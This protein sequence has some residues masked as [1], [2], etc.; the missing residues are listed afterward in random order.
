M[1]PHQVVS[2]ITGFS[3]MTISYDGAIYFAPDITRTVHE[4]VF[5]CKHSS[6]RAFHLQLEFCTATSRSMYQQGGL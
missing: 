5:N 3:A 4:A 2:A 6:K 1:C